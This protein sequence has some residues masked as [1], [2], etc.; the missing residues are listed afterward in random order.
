LNCPV[1]TALGDRGLA[2]RPPSPA[3][4]PTGQLSA[5]VALL[6]G[7]GLA[8][9]VSS[10]F[11]LIG[12]GG[13]LASQT[14]GA[15][16]GAAP[17]IV[18]GVRQ[19]GRRRAAGEQEL[20]AIA[21]GASYGSRLLIASIFGFAVLLVDTAG[22]LVLVNLTKGMVRLTGGDPAR[23]I[24]GYALIG[25]V[26]GLPAVLVA[27]TL[28]AVAAGHRLGAHR[29]RWVLLGLGVYAAVR[30]AMVIAVGPERIGASWLL[31]ALAA[32]VLGPLLVGFAL[33]G[34][35]WA[36]R[37]QAAFNARRFFRRL[38]AEDQQAA[39]ALLEETVGDRR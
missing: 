16:S 11:Q 5:I 26:L 19:R 7:I 1:Q 12:W 35:W 10:L 37:T 22:S 8:V 31:L 25:G 28:L 23:W 4:R 9:A 20:V 29:R 36:R 18:D 3:P 30:L 27:T 38:P 13:E 14:A 24:W 34:T 39:L 21:R 33:I 32:L 15:A 2:A 17:L 6:L